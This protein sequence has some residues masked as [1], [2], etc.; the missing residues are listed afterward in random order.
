MGSAG[1]S[2]ILTRGDG[3]ATSAP[4]ALS[5]RVRVA[6]LPALVRRPRGHPPFPARRRILGRRLRRCDHRGR[7]RHRHRPRCRKRRF[8]RRRPEHHARRRRAARRSR[9]RAPG[10]GLHPDSG[11]PRDQRR[12]ATPDRARFRQRLLLGRQRHDRVGRRL[13]DRQGRRRRHA[14]EALGSRQ[15]AVV[16]RDRWDVPLLERHARSRHHPTHPPR[17]SRRDHAARRR[18]VGRRPRP[19]VA[20]LGDLRGRGAVDPQGRW[21]SHHAGRRAGRRE[22]LRLR[23]RAR[24]EQLLLRRDHVAHRRSRACPYRVGP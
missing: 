22:R 19:D 13:P 6:D 11:R 5:A 23:G 12:P 7:R 21:R 20:L 8:A 16:P 10:H 15:A 14:A 17:R 4:W 18:R 9:G 24:R 1:V 2:A 3:R